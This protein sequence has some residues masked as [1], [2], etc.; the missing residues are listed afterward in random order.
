MKIAEI[1][2][3][4]TEL[5]LGQIVDTHAPTMARLL[6]ECGIGCQRRSTVGDNWDRLVG[7]LRDAL[8][9]SDVVI[10][11]GGLGPTAD[12]LTRDAIAE[13]L[14]DKLIREPE[15]AARLERF[16]TGR[17]LPFSESNLRQADRPESAEFIANPNG[18]APGLLCRKGG[19]VVIALPGPRGE[20]DPMAFGP[21]K[22]VLQTLSG[23]QVIHSR[24]LRVCGLGESHVEKVLG[25]IMDRTQPTVA[26]YAHV[27]EVHLRLTASADD[28]ATADQL[29]DPV[30]GEIRAILGDH[31]YGTDATTLEAAV[32]QELRS[33]NLTVA[34]AES[35]SGGGLAE[36]L[37]SVP[38]ASET[39]VGGVVVYSGQAKQSLLGLSSE[40]V[41]DPVSEEVARALAEAV[42]HK[43]GATFGVAVT[44]NAG[45]TADR[46]GKPVGLV[47]VAVAGPAET[48]VSESSFRG[49]REDVRRRA[50]QTAL[51]MLRGQAVRPAKP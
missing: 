23:G 13:A 43:L 21:V 15:A 10:T 27:G 46:G 37:T 29:I 44:G 34:T 31:V 2:S 18:T 42:R 11:I 39:F 3:V 22:T 48:R 45:P 4:G 49:T 6:A 19:K 24:I 50:S 36:R 47:Y 35:M 33:R 40:A 8:S 20:F 38:G 1:V 9:R 14:G 17:G 32:L 26:P 5:L 16:F 25:A 28:M 51:T 30:E 12:D 7:T 41:S